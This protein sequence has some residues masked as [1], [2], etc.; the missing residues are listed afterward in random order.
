VSRPILWAFG[1]VLVAAALADAREEPAVTVP[2]VE[3]LVERV[4][5]AWDSLDVKLT[6]SMTVVRPG[7]PDTEVQLLIRR[8]GRNRTRIDFLSPP[9]DE[10]KVLLQIGEETW[11]YLPRADRFVEVP[12]RRNPLA[13]G[14][15]FEDLFPGRSELSGAVV[16]ELDDG[17]VLV[18]GA[19]A[20]KKGTSR[21]YFDRSTLLPVRRESYGSSGRLLKTVHIDESRN[22]HGVAI[23]WTV[24]FEDNLRPGNETR[25]EVLR[26]DEL[27]A[28]LEAL[29]SRER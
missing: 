22:W 5:T 26:A 27:E 10:G 15:L 18:T 28:D 13:G 9:K 25:I 2:T 23:P 24:R 11:L 16:E 17:F 3:T 12:A 21:I 6:A 20:K 29:F 1:P 19:S 4:A 8:R 14:V 7:R